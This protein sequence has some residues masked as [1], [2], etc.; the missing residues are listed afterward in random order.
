MSVS[1]Q[2]TP[3]DYIEHHLQHLQLNL[4][5][6]T[7]GPSEDFWTI[8]LDTITM[9]IVLGAIFFSLFYFLARR[10][11]AGVPTRW[12]NFI[13]MAVDGVDSLVKE[14][15]HGVNLL[16][17]PLALTIF[18]W[19][20]LMNFMDIIPVD[21]VPVILNLFGVTHYKAVATADPTLTFA[22]SL[23]VFILVIFYNIKGKGIGG[24]LHEVMS[25]PFGWYL[26]PVN[27]VF[28]LIEEIV[29]PISLSLRLFGNLFAGE[30]VFILIAIMPWYMQYVTGMAWSILHLL[31]ITIQSF[32]FMILTVVYI[33]MAHEKH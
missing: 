16:L 12:Q 23:C 3:S 9:S 29:K 25:K 10:A 15:F 27:I 11:H 17:G 8:N 28:R 7:V 19:V 32:I 13:E 14:T 18:L 31:V 4:H 21:L 5:T 6:F 22:M 33:S 24:F 20:F 2:I 26:F 1:P 30:V